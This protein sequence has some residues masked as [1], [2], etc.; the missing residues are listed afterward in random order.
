MGTYQFTAR[1]YFNER[2]SSTGEGA[3]VIKVT[4]KAAAGTVLYQRN[5]IRS[6]FTSLPRPQQCSLPSASILLATYVANVVLPLVPEG[7]VASFNL[8]A[9]NEEIV[10]LVAPLEEDVFI[11]TDIPPATTANTSPVFSSSAVFLVCP[12]DT[13]VILNNA[14]DADGDR[15]SYRFSTPA[16]NKPTRV[17]TYAPGY[18]LAQP[19]GADGYVSLDANTGVIRFLGR[20]LGAFELAIDVDEYRIINGREVLIGT[21][22]RD[23]Q[24]LIRT[25]TSNNRPPVFTPASL[26]SRSF[27]VEEGRSINFSF[28]ATDPEAQAMTMT[29]SSSLL[30]GPGGIE[31]TVNNQ[32]G[33]GSRTVTVGKVVVLGSGAVTGLFNLQTRCGLARSTPYDVLVTVSDAG[34]ESKTTSALFRITVTQPP[35][36]AQIRGDSVLCTGSTATYTAIGATFGGYQWSVRGGQIIGPATGR[37]I[38]V[39]WTGG[40][41]S[42]VEVRGTLAGDCR[43]AAT[44]KAIA[45]IATPPIE[46]PTLYCRTA[47]TGLRYT[48]AGPPAAY[49][50]AITNGTI[51]EGQGT[52]TVQVDLPPL[53]TATLRVAPLDLAACETILSISP[54]NSCL[55]FYNVVTPNGD[56]KNDAFVIENI[57]RH[58]KTALI[59]F[60]RW[61]RQLYHSDDYHN[62][63][64]GEGTSAGVYYYHCQIADGTAYKGWFEVVR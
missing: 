20:R 22:R 51:V 4:S 6:S 5:V 53:A 17:A 23:M 18:S 54:D 31:A 55:Y 50:W 29:V 11:S 8:R 21:L 43:T 63:Y 2:T 12:G 47:N 9:R 37:A 41:A 57:E 15:L 58:P 24:V 30:D 60:N 38:Q 35:G 40:E 34:C 3:V 10:N 49:Q 13:G 26:V 56:G 32:S 33:D 19:F 27:Q 61:G 52:N 36:L 42:T 44:S 1:L 7:Y 45:S 46:G 64:T 39:R 28:T 62:T 16:N 48:I 25:C 59:I 14:Y